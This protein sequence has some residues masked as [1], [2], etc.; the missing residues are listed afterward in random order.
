MGVICCKIRTLISEIGMGHTYDTI[1]AGRRDM[2]EWL[3]HFTKRRG[4]QS[5]RHI[6]KTILIEGVL[7]P[8]FAPRGSPGRATIYGLLPAVCMT[9]QPIGAFLE[10]LDARG[11]ELMSISG[12]GLLLHKQDIYVAGG[13]P[14]I[15]GLPSTQELAKGVPGYKRDRRILRETDLPLNQQYR[16]VAFSPTR[17]PPL[18]WTHEREWRWSPQDFPGKEHG[19]LYLSCQYYSNGGR[20]RERVHAFVKNDEDIPWLQSEVSDAYHQQKV[21]L[22]PF[23]DD[24]EYKAW[25]RKRLPKVQI[26]S[27]ETARRKISNGKLKYWRFEDWPAS[28]QSPLLLL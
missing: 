1:L 2:T 16:Y 28:N 19:L 13:L 7:R 23:Y 14:V 9:E 5:A 6:L 15:Y 12:Y 18:D 17:T 24:E 8:G 3:I 10:Y 20:F 27:L 22:V 21:G 11:N 26:I 4:M 25:W